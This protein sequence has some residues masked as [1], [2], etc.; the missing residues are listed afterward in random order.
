[1]CSYEHNGDIDACNRAGK[2]LL[3]MVNYNIDSLVE[4]QGFPLYWYQ[5][6]G[7]FK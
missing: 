6:D 3:T 1:M 4:I 2:T 5:A 7:K